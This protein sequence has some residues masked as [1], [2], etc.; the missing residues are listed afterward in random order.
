MWE[1]LVRPPGLSGP[2]V[3]GDV[4]VLGD[5]DAFDCVGPEECEHRRTPLCDL[6]EESKPDG[7]SEFS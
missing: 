5:G 1:T 3:S 6:M 2:D 7:D 4:G